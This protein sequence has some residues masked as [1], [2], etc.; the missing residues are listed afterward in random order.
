MEREEGRVG[1]VSKGIGFFIMAILILAIPGVLLGV[2]MGERTVG[3]PC[4]YR[5]YEGH[6]L[7][8]SITEVKDSKGALRERYEVKF[9]FYPDEEVEEPFAQPEGKEFLL[10]VRGSYPGAEFLKRYR[11]K[12]GKI[13]HCNYKVIV[14][15][16]CSPTVFEFPWIK[17]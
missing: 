14:K 11:I 6:A 3:G 15:G 13:L 5:T 1:V 7:V 10:R 8:T 17:E 12:V 2:S 4:E 9:R 16:T